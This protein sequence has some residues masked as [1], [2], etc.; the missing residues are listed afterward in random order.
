MKELNSI[1]AFMS[2]VVALKA[3]PRTGWNDMDRRVSIPECVGAHSYGLAMLAFAFYH[4]FP[5]LKLNLERLLVICLVHDLVEAKTGDLNTYA[6]QDPV[7]REEFKRHKKKQER[8]AIS[9][10]R[11]EVGGSFG[12]LI[13]ERWE[14]YEFDRNAEARIAHDLDKLEVGIQA[15][16][17]YWAGNQVNPWEF[18]ES[19]RAAIKT[20]E[21]RQYL[22]QVLA[23]SLPT[24]EEVRQRMTGE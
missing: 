23:P 24:R 13:F 9:S 17:Y 3:T 5:E 4:M 12:D 19:S 14:D 15:N 16:A 22:E 7:K 2:V 8:K 20:P 6:I 18:Y 21:V 10:I 11:A 1:Q